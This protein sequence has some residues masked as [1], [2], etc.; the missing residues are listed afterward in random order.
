M[1]MDA[2]D[3][4]IVNAIIAMARSLGLRTTA[5]GV[6]DAGQA[7]ALLAL[8]CDCAQGFHFGRPQPPHTFAQTWLTSPAA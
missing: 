3:H 2:D 4:A 5:E 8:G 6:E 1:L 7:A